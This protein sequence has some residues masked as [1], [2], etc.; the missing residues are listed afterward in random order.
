MQPN[1]VSLPAATIHL[2]GHWPAK[3]AICC[4]AQIS[5]PSILLIR[6]SSAGDHRPPETSRPCKS[7]SSTQSGAVPTFRCA[8]SPAPFVS[9]CLDHPGIICFDSGHIRKLTSH[10]VFEA[11]TRSDQSSIISACLGSYSNYWNRPQYA[12]HTHLSRRSTAPHFGPRKEFKALALT[13]QSS[14]L[15]R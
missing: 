7:C 11:Q 13:P 12:V 5:R 14:M 10:W 6:C 8:A 4:V 2:L 9:C 15:V 1:E 3:E